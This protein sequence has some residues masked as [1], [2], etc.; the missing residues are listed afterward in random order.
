MAAPGSASGWHFG[1][2]ARGPWIGDSKPDHHAAASKS[3]GAVELPEGLPWEEDAF[4]ALGIRTAPGM[5]LIT[6]A[7]MGF[8]QKKLFAFFLALTMRVPDVRIRVFICNDGGM[9][10]SF[11]VLEVGDKT[12]HSHGTQSSRTKARQQAAEQVIEKSGLYEYLATHHANTTCD[13]HL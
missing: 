12:F 4:D 1:P 5:S 2:T 10:H 6:W 11:V 13:E 3:A 8:W 9:A 7:R